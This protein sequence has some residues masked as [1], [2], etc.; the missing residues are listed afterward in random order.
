[1]AGAMVSH[2]TQLAGSGVV[3]LSTA[4]AG[5]AYLTQIRLKLC[6]LAFVS[7]HLRACEKIVASD[8]RSHFA[9]AQER[10]ARSETPRKPRRGESQG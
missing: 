8:G 10:F 6:A 2:K 5:I 1:M 9:E 7:S 4:S 3:G